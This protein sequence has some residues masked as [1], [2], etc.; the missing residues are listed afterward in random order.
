M[1]STNVRFVLEVEIEGDSPIIPFIAGARCPDI[2]RAKALVEFFLVCH[3]FLV[4]GAGVWA[5]LG[6]IILVLWSWN[7]DGEVEEGGEEEE[8]VVH[9]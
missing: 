3:I 5:G 4:D 1:K 7:G 2:P 9:N 6:V 8:E